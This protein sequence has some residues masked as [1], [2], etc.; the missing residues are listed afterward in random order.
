MTR[1]V[2]LQ[3]RDGVATITLSALGRDG[4]RAGFDAEL[5][6]GLA[7]AIE[8]VGQ[9]PGTRAVI[10]RAGPE[11]WPVS[12]D[13]V[14]DFTESAG[15]PLAQIADLLARLP[16]PVLALLAGQI[17]G[18]GL[19][20]AAAARLRLAL[21]GTRFVMR[22][23]GLGVFPAAGTLVRLAR[24]V[25]GA[26]M[27]ACVTEGRVLEAK[28]AMARGLCDAVVGG[29]TVE[30][31]A[32]A[33]ALEA[34]TNG[35][36]VGPDPQAALADT[37]KY[38]AEM[39]AARAGPGADPV[40]A[41]VAARVAEVL[42]AAA[43]LPLEEAL[44]FEAVA[45]E[46][47]LAE[48]RTRALRHADAGVRALAVVPGYGVPDAEALRWR[49]TVGLWNM[50][51]MLALTLIR[52]GYRV[53]YAGEAQTRLELARKRIAA[54]LGEALPE[55][56][57]AE[58]MGRLSLATEPGALAGA[59]AILAVLP[60]ETE[61]AEALASELRAARAPGAL[62]ALDGVE[63]GANELGFIRRGSL[64]EILP[65][66]EMAAADVHRLRQI[67]AR[68]G[69]VSIRGGARP[70]ISDRLEA[71]F[72]DAAERCVMAGATP[73]AVDK[74]LE[75]YG[76]AV[77][78]MRRIDEIGVPRVVA[79]LEAA[80][81]AVG[82]Y[83]NYLLLAGQ[84]GR[85]T[86]LGSYVWSGE[87][88]L[89]PAPD[90]AETLSVLREEAGIAPRRL[91]A[92]EIVA[93]MMSEL[94]AEGAALIQSEGAHRASDV[95]LAALIVLGLGRYRGGPLFWADEAG[96]LQVRKRLRA[97]ADEGAPPPVTLWDVLIR[98]GKHFAD[99]TG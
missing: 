49:G 31:A 76:F 88:N 59:G 9:E 46:D 62:L 34:M 2:K 44:D 73:E 69:V 80:H 38:L 4:A 16:V 35:D 1:R 28:G 85:A 67:M 3:R 48:P 40:L 36:G 74:A 70:G 47:L 72:F 82:P 56:Q 43:L 25:G 60:A 41:P 81:R 95:D 17:A 93:R 84:S 96:L 11:G 58:I 8:L 39:A 90:L 24:R 29:G 12:E 97:L 77:G 20:L 64:R 42:E 21:P 32:I 26:R 37:G 98:N 91:G 23:F 19:A 53:I 45:F 75:A 52:A 99:I 65:G 86:E 13:P 87:T 10:L 61:T 66:A 51:D 79:G 27:F 94:A 7:K 18:G 6:A 78:P 63:V 50:G 92:P 33:T 14:T 54:R 83:L 89:G 57:L 22:E 5:R 15:V 30:T 55:A 68:T 71:A